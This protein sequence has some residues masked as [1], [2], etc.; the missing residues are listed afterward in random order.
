MF[1]KKICSWVII[2]CVAVPTLSHCPA[3]GQATATGHAT[4]A[5]GHTT[6][7]GHAAGQVSDAA[8]NET[9]TIKADSINPANYFGETVANG[10]LGIVSSPQPFTVKDIVL[11]GAFDTYGR[12]AVSNIMK[13]FN[14]VNMYLDVDG[15][16]IEQASQVGHLTQVLDMKHAN[17]ST[18]F[19]YGDKVS[20]RCTYYALRQLPY[21]ALVDIRIKALTDVEIGV[22]SVMEAPDMLQGVQNYYN[23]VDGPKGPLP[24][25]ISTA[26]SPTGKLLIAAANSFV[27]DE[28]AGAL[29]MVHH[30]MQDNNLH[31]MNFN[32]KLRAGETYHFAVVGSSLTSAHEEDPL[33]EVQRLTIFA[34]LQGTD[35]LLAAHDKAWN[36]LWKSDI[37]IDGDDATQ[38]EVRSMIYHLYAFS[39]E[40][41]AYSIS[42]MGL[43]G[44]GYNG[45]IFWD[46]ETW[47]YPAL[48][49]LQPKIAAS[50]MEYRFQRLRQAERNAF[51][52]GYR[53]AMYPWESAASGEEETP[54]GALTG[55]FEHHITADI[56][57]AAWNYFCVTQDKEWLKN[58]G[59][60]LLKE[61]ADF[62]ASRVE[63]N[64]AGHYDIKNVVPADED[65]GN[66]DNNAFTNA[67]AKANLQDATEAAQLLGLPPDPDWMEVSRN[68]PIL[69]FAGGITMEHA[70][71]H[72]EKIK[73]AD[74][75]LLA[76]PLH[77]ITDPAA[78]RK[79]LE[80]YKP[81]VGDGPAMTQAIFAI[82]YARLGMPDSAYAVFKAGYT[83]NM[84]P[85][86]GVIAET[87]S[88]DNPYFSTGAGGMLQAMLN[89]FGGLE[90]TRGGISQLKT[91]LPAAWHSLKLT[92]IG[93]GGKTYTVQ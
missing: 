33:N 40:G 61:T 67:A 57:M 23:E 81:R 18:S 20:V 45:H 77:E 56:G 80:Y 36:E 84:R 31:I 37:I 76:Y 12:G 63:R 29:P 25:L 69:R 24:L 5:M 16:R 91:T 47:M 59:Y 53:G 35:Q 64:G 6:A 39:R 21:T 86:F 7:T 71:Y 10:M 26:R 70:T 28:P 89:G 41:T 14:F 87:A 27:F 15:S 62:W 30:A 90:I 88:G 42:P 51:S 4:T 13:T 1:C 85:P 17:L 66:V 34:A 11:N 75:N 9:W 55:P 82:L 54:V 74:V 46:A 92:G 48:L 58:K 49:L 83:P 68:I 65:A 2:C 93:P 43:S 78:I 44:L 52:H 73:Q 72:G 8:Q 60:P 22:A 32:K 38:R 50:M 3:M 19:D 79:D